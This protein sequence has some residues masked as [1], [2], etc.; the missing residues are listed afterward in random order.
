VTDSKGFTLI[1]LAI[2]LAII[3]ILA[4]VAMPRS[5][6]LS[7]RAGDAA[8]EATAASVQAAYAVALADSGAAPSCNGLF[9][10]MSRISGTGNTR[11]IA[12]SGSTTTV[13]C[14]ESGGRVSSVS[15]WNDRAATHRDAD[16]A[17]VL[18]F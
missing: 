7:G 1:E 17:L 15:I 8:V 6:D 16:S 18:S 2:V 9:S 11:T 5:A 10:R 14:T 4:A 12:S 13:A 3:A